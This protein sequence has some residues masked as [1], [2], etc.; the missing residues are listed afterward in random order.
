[1]ELIKDIEYIGKRSNVLEHGKRYDVRKRINGY[2]YVRGMAQRF[3][4]ASFKFPENVV[5]VVIK[6]SLG[7][8]LNA[9]IGKVVTCAFAIEYSDGERRFNPTAPCHAAISWGS[10][11]DRNVNK[12]AK[13]VALFNSLKFGYEGKDKEELIRCMTWFANESLYKEAFA[14]PFKPE[15]VNDGVYMNV[16]AT[17]NTIAGALIGMRQFTEHPQMRKNFVKFLDLGYSPNV[18]YVAACLKVGYSPQVFRSSGGG[19]DMLHRN[20][21]I[22]DL[23][24]TFNEG[25]LNHVENDKPYNESRGRGYFV[26]KTISP[27]ELSCYA[28]G[29][30]P[31]HSGKA[32]HD[33][34]HRELKHLDGTVLTFKNER[35][36]ERNTINKWIEVKDS[37][38]ISFVPILN[39]L[40]KVIK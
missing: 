39:A 12:N 40:A 22:D 8:E 25:K 3:K 23:A 37:N 28:Y 2:V 21:T 34:V 4:E 20:M 9:K 13:P 16:N 17:M 6:Q 31:D 14:T 24:K 35:G 38:L 29:G 27:N 18:S 7:D 10:Y 5:K 19:H 1:M 32:V 26:W 33:Y 30:K 15:M 36:W 11:N